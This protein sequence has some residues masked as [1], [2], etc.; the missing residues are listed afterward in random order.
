MAQFTDADK[1]RIRMHLE[2][3]DIE[4]GAVSFGGVLF[5]AEPQNKLEY[6]MNHMTVNGVTNALVTVGYLQTIQ[7]QQIDALSRLQ[8]SK[9]DVVTLNPEE[10]N[11]LAK[12]YTYWQTKLANQ[13]S[14]EVNPFAKK[15]GIGVNVKVQRQR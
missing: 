3:P 1:S 5:A 12:Q 15:S 13:L 9:A 8:A 10:L 11:A 14:V 7:A 2:Y 4:S 6:A